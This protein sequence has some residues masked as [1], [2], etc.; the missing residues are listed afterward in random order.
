MLNKNNNLKYKTV[1][2]DLDRRIQSCCFDMSL[3]LALLLLMAYQDPRSDAENNFHD[4]QKE[5][6][7]LK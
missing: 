1:S 3:L 7:H 4:I 2:S 6:V 5:R